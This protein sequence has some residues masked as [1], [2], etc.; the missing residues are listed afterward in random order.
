MLTISLKE[1]GK[2]AGPAI[3]YLGSRLEQQ[4]NVQRNRVTLTN[5]N[6][7]TAKLLLQKFL[8]QT[9]LEDYRIVV[10]RPG[11]IEVRA[12]EKEKRGAVRADEGARPS[13]WETVPDLWYLTPP[14]IVRPGKRSKRAAKR[15]VRGL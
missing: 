13:A 11:L 7:R 9:R 1:L 3:Q 8:R 14:G 4:A 15:V 6:A 10:V 12:P 2:H 5:T